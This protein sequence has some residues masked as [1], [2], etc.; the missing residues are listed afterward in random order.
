MDLIFNLTSRS[1]ILLP[2]AVT[3]ALASPLHRC[4]RNTLGAGGLRNCHNKTHKHCE[5][6]NPGV[7]V[8]DSR[9]AAAMG[10]KECK[11]WCYAEKVRTHMYAHNCACWR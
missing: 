1:N 6:C 2:L 3:L 5:P 8:G 9:S 11:K 10:D 4:E 7:F